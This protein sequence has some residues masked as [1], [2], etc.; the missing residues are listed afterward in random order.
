MSALK[1]PQENIVLVRRGRNEDKG[2]KLG[3]AWKL[4][5]A[6][7]VTAM[8]AFFLLMWLLSSPKPSDLA[9]M[10]D[11]F[12]LTTPNAT[13]TAGQSQSDG[14]QSQTQQSQTIKAT[15]LLELAQQEMAAQ[16]EVA[17]QKRLESL[18]DQIET[19]I[20]KDP[21]AR[22]LKEQIR[23]ENSVEG[24]LIQLIDG[25]RRP[26]FD[27]GS[28]SLKPYAAEVMTRLTRI[29]TEVNNRVAITG[30][31]DAKPFTS[32]GGQYSNWELSSD[33][34]NST[35]RQ[36]VASGMPQS[37]VMR[38]VGM[39]SASPMSP[40]LDDPINRRIEILVLTK[41]SEVAALQRSI[42]EGLQNQP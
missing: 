6:D 33:R 21:E 17:D 39:A 40:E 35:R 7:F 31:T 13:Q 5:Y 41:K 38:V 9:G 25:G 27:S 4:A 26:M 10:A 42:L 23:L 2:G 28:A 34:A 32:K 12:T 8:M 16:Q 36:M 22:Q 18:K 19:M 15:S 29:L 24:L 37:Q 1:K 30:H 11:Y 14:Q 3:G 20:E